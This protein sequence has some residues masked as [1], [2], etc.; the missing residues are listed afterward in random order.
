MGGG[1]SV[2][3]VLVICYEYGGIKPEPGAVLTN[4]FFLGRFGQFAI[5]GVWLLI[6]YLTGMTT[7]CSGSDKYSRDK[8]GMVS[9]DKDFGF[10]FRLVPG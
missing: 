1:G 7:R 5:S 6:D 3:F 8:G 10:D 2:W 4:V 9:M